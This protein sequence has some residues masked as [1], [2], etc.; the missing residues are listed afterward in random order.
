MLSP[1]SSGALATI[2]TIATSSSN[3]IQP[4]IGPSAHLA[5][6]RPER[7]GAD[8]EVSAQL[9]AATSKETA[10]LTSPGLRRTD[11]AATATQAPM[12]SACEKCSSL[13]PDREEQ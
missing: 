5:G 12:Q 10:T 8:H 6:I 13:P 7:I 4:V 3:A 1:Y 2:H 9:G 11:L